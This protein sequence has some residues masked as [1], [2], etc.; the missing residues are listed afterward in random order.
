M[1]QFQSVAQGGVDITELIKQYPVTAG[2]EL[3]IGGDEQLEQELGLPDT[4]R[5]VK[6]GGE[7]I[8]RADPYQSSDIKE[9]M[10]LHHSSHSIL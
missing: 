9:Q 2:G 1:G 7:V 3:A 8:Q 10:T 4:L 5:A 6:V